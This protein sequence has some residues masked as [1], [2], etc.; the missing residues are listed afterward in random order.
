MA[1]AAELVGKKSAC[2][3]GSACGMQDADMKRREAEEGAEERA[4]AEAE[5]PE[6]EGSETVKNRKS[7]FRYTVSPLCFIMNCHI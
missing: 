6:V 2:C 7:C 1:Q 3:K 5:G 4:H